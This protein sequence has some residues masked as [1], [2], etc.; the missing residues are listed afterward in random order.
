MVGPELK[1]THLGYGVG[2]S[3]PGRFEPATPLLSG[4][5]VEF[6][7]ST[8]SQIPIKNDESKGSKVIPL[9]ISAAQRTSGIQGVQD[10]NAP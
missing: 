8:P 5:A 1:G 6:K 3:Q 2:R 4:N 7:S 10:R 9:S